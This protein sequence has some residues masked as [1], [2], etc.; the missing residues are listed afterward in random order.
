MS[1]LTFLPPSRR[2]V[3]ALAATAALVLLLAACGDD[4]GGNVVD[5]A[6]KDTGLPTQPA[7]A[8]TEPTTT[9]PSVAGAECVEATDV[10]EAEGK[11]TVEMPVGEVPTELQ[12][13]DITEGDGAE[14]ELGKAITVDYVGIACSTGMQFDASYDNGEPVEFPLEEGG[15]IEGWIEGIPG[16]KVGG[17]RMLVIPADLAY[18]A[19]GNQGIAPGEALVFVID[20][21]DVTDAPAEGEAPTDE[22]PVEDAPATT[23][24]G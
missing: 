21:K 22:A 23:V 18:G 24:A 19:E 3:A 7:P 15:L 10:P 11:P 20:L 14:A 8:P 16:M 2:R 5:D 13:N 4:S 12:S 6:T 1:A 9:L 17:R